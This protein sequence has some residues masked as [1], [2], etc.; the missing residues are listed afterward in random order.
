MPTLLDASPDDPRVASLMQ[1][2]QRELRALYNDTDERTEPFDPATL[3]GEGS[4]LVAVEEGGALLACGALKCLSH[5]TA[6]IKRMYTV[7]EAR[8][9]GLGRRVLGALIERG[10]A[11]GYA[12]LVL[13]TGDLQAEALRLYG[14]AGFVRIPN[15]GYYV[16]ME[17]S[18]CYGLQLEAEAPSGTRLPPDPYPQT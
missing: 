2:Q 14:S 17:N 6:E 13:E 16:G 5:D 7:P 9:Q 12:R 1:A 18:L 15:Y 3:A 11:L 10:R 4:A 8:G